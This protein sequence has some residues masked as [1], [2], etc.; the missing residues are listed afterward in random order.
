MNP[1]CE[2]CSGRCCTFKEFGIWQDVFHGNMRANHHDCP[3]CKD[4]TK[5]NLTKKGQPRKRVAKLAVLTPEQAAA[6]KKA[7]FEQYPKV[8]EYFVQ[9]VD[10][11]AQ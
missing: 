1:V 3:D 10:P 5:P 8:K 2:T 9:H 11:D 6:E 7:F 4:G